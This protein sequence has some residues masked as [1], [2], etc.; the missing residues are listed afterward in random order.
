MEELKR[1]IA[2]YGTD[3][4]EAVIQA[5]AA[6]SDIADVH[7]SVACK[8]GARLSMALQ[9]FA[10]ENNQEDCIPDYR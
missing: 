1:F 5:I 8:M 2:D 10:R 4:M 6:R 9:E 3:G 7:K